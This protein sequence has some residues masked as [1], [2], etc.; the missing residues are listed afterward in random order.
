MSDEDI[1]KMDR[2]TA[3][4]EWGVRRRASTQ[5]GIDAETKARLTA[6]AEKARARMQEAGEASPGGDT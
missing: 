6:E 2:V 5:P 1:A 3:M 4:R